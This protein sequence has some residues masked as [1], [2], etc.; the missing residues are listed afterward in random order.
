VAVGFTSHWKGLET[1]SGG[2]SM[3]QETPVDHALLF[4]SFGMEQFRIQA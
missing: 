4:F 2:N 3:Y 1:P